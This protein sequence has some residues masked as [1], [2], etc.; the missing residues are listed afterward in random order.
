MI[1]CPFV[2]NIYSTFHLH[3]L[4]LIHIFFSLFCLQPYNETLV[5]ILHYRSTFSTIS[6]SV[7]LQIIHFHQ[8][9]TSTSINDR[10][11]HNNHHN[12]NLLINIPH[13]Y[14]NTSPS[15]RA[16]TQPISSLNHRS[17]YIMFSSYRTNLRLLLSTMP[18]HELLSLIQQ[19]SDML[20]QFLREEAGYGATIGPA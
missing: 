15:F 6:R 3:C 4:T 18:Y 5:S 9:T 1:K 7:P 20:P 19:R 2:P 16:Q 11:L 14:F 8:T 12:D 17:L 10:N 13:I